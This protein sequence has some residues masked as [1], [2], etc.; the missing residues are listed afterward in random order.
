MLLLFDVV[1][2]ADTAV[3]PP[4]TAI[5]SLAA[6]SIVTRHSKHLC[7]C[8]STCL[9]LDPICSVYCCVLVLF[10]TGRGRRE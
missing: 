2:T 7:V 9:L 6:A 10:V 4:T 1:A 8:V 3:S 5:T